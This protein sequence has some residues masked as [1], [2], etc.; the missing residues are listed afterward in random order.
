[1]SVTISDVMNI[2]MKEGRGFSRKISGRYTEQ[3]IPG[4]PLEQTIGGV[5]LN[6]TAVKDLGIEEAGSG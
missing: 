5:V 6:E 4:G 3:W 2:A 1:M